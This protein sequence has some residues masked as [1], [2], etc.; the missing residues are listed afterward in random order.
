MRCYRKQDLSGAWRS[1]RFSWEVSQKKTWEVF[2][3]L[4]PFPQFHDSI[5][6][7]SVG[8]LSL[9]LLMETSAFCVEV[10]G[11]PLGVVSRRA[12][13]PVW[14]C[15]TFLAVCLVFH[16]LHTFLATSSNFPAPNLLFHALHAVHKMS[17]LIVCSSLG[18]LLRAVGRCSILLL[19]S[20]LPFN[21]S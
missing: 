14:E 17:C 1:R 18:W 2:F 19:P 10:L 15:S 13:F 6:F 3:L 9:S 7:L 21:I 12:W 16:H 11:N 5:F 4:L 20:I 8:Y